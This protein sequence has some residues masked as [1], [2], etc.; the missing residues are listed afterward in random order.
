MGAVAVQGTGNSTAN[1]TE[2]V[3]EEGSV[4]KPLTISLPEDL[5]V[6]SAKT[7]K[8]GEAQPVHAITYR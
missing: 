3:D 2:E 8:L 5:S 6:S 1:I 4:A 7:S